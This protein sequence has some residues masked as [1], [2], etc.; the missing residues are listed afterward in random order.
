MNDLS[1]RR[2]DW[3]ARPNTQSEVARRCSKVSSTS[4]QRE[5]R[6]E[7]AGRAVLSGSIIRPRESNQ[8]QRIESRTSH[9]PCRPLVQ[10]EKWLTG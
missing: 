8:L 3:K 10:C 1:E 6:L 9:P 5:E 7:E 2:A 4:Q